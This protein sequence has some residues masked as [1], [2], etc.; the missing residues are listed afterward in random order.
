MAT[1]PI[2]FG[3]INAWGTKLNTWLLVSHNPDGTEIGGGGGGG[4]TGQTLLTFSVPGVLVGQTGVMQWPVSVNMTIHDVTVRVATPP[5]GQSIVVDVNKNGSTI[6]T[7]QANRPLIA[8][9]TNVSTQAVPDL[10]SLV[11]G[12]YLT[13]DIDQVG[14]LV[15]GSDLVYVV[16]CT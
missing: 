1:L 9:G 6:F 12:D 8:L 5:T 16:R 7:T 2:N 10:T 11:V 3:D 13:F 15:K 4:G 14:T